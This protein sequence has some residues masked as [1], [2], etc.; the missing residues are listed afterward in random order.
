MRALLLLVLV[1]I[2]SVCLAHSMEDAFF[3]GVSSHG[4]LTVIRVRNDNDGPTFPY[5]ISEDP[6]FRYC[7]A[8]W[9][10][11]QCVESF[12]G[13]PTV[14]YKSGEYQ[15]D[16]KYPA[17]PFKGSGVRYEDAVIYLKKAM[18]YVD[19]TRDSF[20]GYYI[21]DKGCSDDNA[22]V[23]IFSFQSMYDD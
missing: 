11:F 8:E 21:C 13:K 12:E 4:E 22:P 6:M 3:I 18:A 20:V 14:V 17:N 1:A 5:G 19:K 15:S 7:K 16:D 2:P 23:F 10:I 9:R